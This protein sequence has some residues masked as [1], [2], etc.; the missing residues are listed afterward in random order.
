VKGKGTERIAK[1]HATHRGVQIAAWREYA[2]RRYLPAMATKRKNIHVSMSLPVEEQ[3]PLLAG[4]VRLSIT[5]R[6][7]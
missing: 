3:P 6:D 5:Q 7:A 2:Y 4:K 1:G